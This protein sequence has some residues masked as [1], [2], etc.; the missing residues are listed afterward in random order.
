MPYRLGDIVRLVETGRFLQPPQGTVRVVPERRGEGY[1]CILVW[2]FEVVGVSADELFLRAADG[3][4]RKVRVDAPTV[5]RDW[6]RTWVL[7][8]RRGWRGLLHRA[9][10]TLLR[11][12]S[13]N[14]QALPRRPGF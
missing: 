13:K 4:S 12:T 9:K 6:L 10:P 8:C 5:H 11:R 2:R 3:S 7:R 14:V 1:R